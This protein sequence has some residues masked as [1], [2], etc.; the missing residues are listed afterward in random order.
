MNEA[1][2]ERAGYAMKYRDALTAQARDGWQ[3]IETA[4]KDLRVIVWTGQNIYVAKWV[5]NILNDH[6]AFMICETGVPG[7]RVIVQPTHWMPCPQQPAH[8]AAKGE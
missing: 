7:E 4:P 8:A 5:K 6:E 1:K 3:P 2:N